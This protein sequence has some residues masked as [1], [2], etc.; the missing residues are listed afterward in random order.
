MNH[1]QMVRSVAIESG[2]T[3]D[4]VETVLR[5]LAETV[6]SATASGDEVS[7]ASLGKFRLSVYH[8]R[9]S[10]ADEPGQTL[11]YGKLEFRCTAQLRESLTDGLRKEKAND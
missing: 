7:V 2:L 5:A 6:K 3:Q 10:F 4:T 9:D 1:D 8:R 11:P